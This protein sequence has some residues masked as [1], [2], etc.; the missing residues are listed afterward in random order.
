MTR[1]IMKIRFNRRSNK[2][3][4]EKTLDNP[5]IKNAIQNIWL[6]G[7]HEFY[8]RYLKKKHSSIKKRKGVRIDEKS[9]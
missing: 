6:S 1:K 9:R 8:K 5:T 2:W 7:Y 3:E 4:K